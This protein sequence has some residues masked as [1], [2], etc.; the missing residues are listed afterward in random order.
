MSCIKL[1]NYYI[2]DIDKI[3]DDNIKLKTKGYGY[4]TVTEGLSGGYCRVK[5]E[6]TGWVTNAKF[7]NLVYGKV[8]DKMARTAYGVGVIGSKYPTSMNGKKVREYSLW[9]SILS[10]VYSKSERKSLSTYK[11]CEVSENFKSYEYFYEWCNNQVG[12]NSL[13]E[14]GK[15]FEIDKDLLIKNNKVYSE[16]G[17][18]FIPHSLNTLL[19]KSNSIRGEHL[20]GVCYNKKLNKYQAN[21]KKYSKLVYMGLF[22]TELDAFNAYK[23]EK[24]LY[25]KELAQK[26][27]NDI[28]ERSYVAL[29]NYKVDIND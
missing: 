2:K 14:K 21:I 6:D 19:V 15:Y 12:F 28:D 3:I 1:N 24:E 16:D 4:L 29:L 10:R 7:D 11:G 17:C 27:Q 9:L 18:V 23:V 20:I 26:Y 25:V 22:D 13:D 8:R 5:F